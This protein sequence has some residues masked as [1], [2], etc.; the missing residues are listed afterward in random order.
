MIK[1]TLDLVDSVRL[2]A[3]CK[4]WW[5]ASTCDPTKLQCA[6]DNLVWITQYSDYDSISQ[7][8]ICL[9]R[10]EKYTTDL[11][12]FYRSVKIKMPD[13]EDTSSP[14]DGSFSIVDGY[15]HHVVLF[16]QTFL[17]NL[18]VAYPGDKSW[19]QHCYAGQRMEIDSRAGLTVGDHVYC[20][21]IC[22]VS[23]MRLV[24]SHEGEIMKVVP[25]ESNARSLKI[26]SYSVKGE[27]SKVYVLQAKRNLRIVRALCGYQ[28]EVYNLKDG[29]KEI[30]SQDV[31]L[32]SP[33]WVDMG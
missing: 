26:Y 30:L 21:D 23:W 4:N 7:E 2:A 18:K 32:P 16:K 22:G 27:G 5:L 17:V 19:S 1:D 28:I 10:D 31:Y 13:V 25:K 11:P 14:Y 33:E 15:P 8:F 12:E 24:V 20:F 29:S 3:V 9:S 6:R